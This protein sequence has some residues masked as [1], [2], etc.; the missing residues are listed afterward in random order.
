VCSVAAIYFKQFK[1]VFV[2]SF[3]SLFTA[4]VVCLPWAFVIASRE[5]DFWNYFFWVEHIQRFMANNAQ[6]KSPFW[7][8]IPILLAAVLPWL[9]YLFVRYDTHGSKR[10][11]Y[12]FS[13][14]VYRAICFFQYY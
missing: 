8:Y 12:L 1:E 14:M 9:G 10:V 2:F 11:T 4:F 5:P 6:N 7:F 13:I 3:V